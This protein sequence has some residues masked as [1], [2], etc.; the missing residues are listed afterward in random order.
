LKFIFTP[1]TILS[2]AL[3]SMFSCQTTEK[4]T[5]YRPKNSS[6]SKIA[7]GTNRVHAKILTIKL[8][9]TINKGTLTYCSAKILRV[10]GTGGAVKSV[11]QNQ[12]LTLFVSQQFRDLYSKNNIQFDD[13]FQINKELTLSIKPIS[14]SDNIWKVVELHY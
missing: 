5:A 2:F 6:P 11:T 7:R 1:F 4:T 12:E 8:E 10:E 3:L 9:E 14:T 13:Y